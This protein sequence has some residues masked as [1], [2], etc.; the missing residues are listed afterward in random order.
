MRGS[1]PGGERL[2]RY[3]RDAGP[4]GRE[5]GR[6]GGAVR[7]RRGRGRSRGGPVAG[8][9]PGRAAAGVQRAAVG[10]AAASSAPGGDATR[11]TCCPGCPGGCPALGKHPRAGSGV[12][13][14]GCVL[15]LHRHPLPPRQGGLCKTPW[16]Q[17]PFPA[18]RQLL[19][20]CGGRLGANSGCTLSVQLVLCSLVSTV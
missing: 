2:S 10:L 5:G 1:V 12:G 8:R 17:R 4:G 14:A 13:G 3:C 19:R 9:G 16:K 7:C 6:G 15:H 11:V 20:C 18:G